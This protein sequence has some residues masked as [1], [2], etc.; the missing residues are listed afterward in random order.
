[1]PTCFA[2]VETN[3]CKVAYEIT[4]RQGLFT[5]HSWPVSVFSLNNAK[6]IFVIYCH[7]LLD[8]FRE[9]HDPI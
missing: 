5:L 6:T 8:D 9:Q 1:M 2:V 4:S 7:R 3:S